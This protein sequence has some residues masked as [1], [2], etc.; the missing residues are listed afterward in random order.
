MSQPKHNHLVRNIPNTEE[1]RKFIKKVNKMSKESDS[2][3]KLF[4]KY[5]KPKE[6]FHYGSGGSLKCKNANAFSVYIDDRRP[7]RDR[8]SERHRSNLFSQVCELE[9]ENE[10]LK[11]ELT[12]FK[13]PYMDWSLDDI[14]A[15]L[16][17]IKEKIVEDFLG[18]FVD[19]KIWEYDKVYRK[20]VQEKYELLSQARTY[21][22]EEGLKGELNETYNS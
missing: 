20:I 8:P 16:F 19:K 22:L 1:N 9:E 4:I 15:E 17:G 7:H 21:K 3:W 14:E 5:R 10:K 2:I 12:I 6:G 18:E 13:N 11:K